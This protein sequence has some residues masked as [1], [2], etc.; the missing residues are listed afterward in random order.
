M[1]CIA[2]FFAGLGVQCFGGWITRDPNNP[3]TKIL[4]QSSFG[5]NHYWANNFNDMVG[6]MNVLFNLLV[7]NN[8]TEC[9]AGFSA[10]ANNQGPKAYFLAFYLVGVILVKN[11]VIAFVINAFIK[12]WNLRQLESQTQ[13]QAGTALIRGHVAELDAE[14]VTGTST[15]IS[16][17]YR[18]RIKRRKYRNETDTQILTDLLTQS[19]RD[20]SGHFHTRD[21][22]ADTGRT[23]QRKSTYYR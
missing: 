17:R 18:A 3:S 5:V 7:E 15:N 4:E 23:S 19:S 22:L 13:V 11:L 20:S 10:L 14:N 21:S 6:A 16:G 9:Y 8:W 12:E 2:Y 1:F